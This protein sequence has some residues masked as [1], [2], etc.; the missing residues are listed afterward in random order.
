MSERKRIEYLDFLRVL[1]T[2][3]VVFYH[4][5]AGSEIIGN[6]ITIAF[7]WCVPIFIMISGTLFL[8][9]DKLVTEKTIFTKTL[10]RIIGIIFVWGMFYNVVSKFIIEGISINA[11]IESLIMVITADTTYCY[12]FWY[13]YLLVGLYILIPIIKPWVDK[14]M[15]SDKPTQESNIVFI[16]LMIVSLIIP[17]TLRIVGFEGTVWKG[18]FTVFTAFVFYLFTGTYL[19]RWDMPKGIKCFVGVTFVAQVIWFSYNMMHGQYE[20]ICTWFGYESFFTWEMSVIVYSLAKKF[21]K[22]I[23]NSVG[24]KLVSVISK[25]SLGIY[26]LHVMVLMFLS[27]M[28]FS[29]NI[30]NIYVFPIINVA[31]T[32]VICIIGSEIISRIPIIK[33]LI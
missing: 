5:G 7:N 2:I 32:I 26:I 30:I 18:A 6:I 13:L 1:A 23:K 28:G 9:K 29:S 10:P 15:N 4:T 12:Q 17:T 31:I 20:S 19:Y 11:F 21:Y 33:K 16:F 25:N 24:K 8:R 22:P 3:A 27:K 14:Y